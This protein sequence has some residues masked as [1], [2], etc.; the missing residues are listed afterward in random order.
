MS[1]YTLEV[2]NLSKAFPGVQALD[3]VSLRVR[4]GHV[5]A[6]M[7][8][9]G[10]GK[11]TLMKCLLGLYRPD[12]GRILF[13][14]EELRIPHPS[15]ALAKG[16]AM[17]HQELNPVAERPVM[18]NIWLGRFP[19][20]R[21]GPL[22]L[23]DAEAMYVRTRAIFEDLELNLDP[24]ERA[25]NLT[26]A[27]M[28]MMEI[29][30]AVSY[31]SELLIMDEPTS[32]LTETEIAQ[33]FK[34]IR[35]LRSQGVAIIYISHKME[36][37]FRIC[38]EVTVL[39]DGKFVGERDVASLTIEE[40]IRMMVG[41]E[42]TSLFPKQD[43]PLGDVRLRVEDLSSPGAFE[44][45]TFDLRRGE[46]LGFAGLVGAGRTELMETL[47]GLRPISSGRVLIDGRETRIRSPRDA[48]RA[49]FAFLTEDRRS[50]GIIGVGSVTD[51]T[52]IANLRAYVKKPSRLLDFTRIRTDTREY[53]ERL[54]TRTPSYE[55]RIQ[56]LSGGNQQKVLVAR[57]L[58]TRPDI[59]ILD[60]PTRGIDVGAK[61]EIHAIISEL[62]AEGNSILLVSSELPEI[63]GMSDRIVVMHEG[64]Q[65]AIL[66]RKD[67]SQ[68]LIMKYATA[69]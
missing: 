20:R 11:S 59:L 6:V 42:L 23:V 24:R 8:E 54:R 51:N 62:A 10:A 4:P 40:L 63:L 49:G 32:S 41:R 26:V 31:N 14:G 67:A 43:V 60:E 1:D 61:A 5:H 28:Q 34:I 17:I 30:K 25:G 57:W 44:N 21:F 39:R 19:K 66:E 15:V 52:I 56:N 16:I 27:K 38:D 9:N 2:E 65:T 18:E 58:L 53:N 33:L 45:V 22:S 47:F 46:I 69:V 50:T 7:G 48:K 3:G 29:A 37:I 64:R 35:R 12:S 36:E 68:E 55:T 13:K